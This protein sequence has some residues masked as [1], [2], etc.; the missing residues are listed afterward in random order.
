WLAR[1]PTLQQK[2]APLVSRVRRHA[3]LMVLL[4]RFAPRLRTA[5]APA[6]A[7]GDASPRKFSSL[8]LLAA[9]AWAAV[10]LVLVAWLGPTYLARYGL[11]GWRGALAVGVVIVGVFKVLG[12]Y[13][14]RAMERSQ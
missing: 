10:L 1:Y 11:G 6:P 3:S 14:R 12:A 5:L 9:F 4:I 8:N 2:T 7:A 13:E